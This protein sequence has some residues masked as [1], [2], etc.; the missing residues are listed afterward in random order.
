MKE[1][2]INECE[3][4]IQYCGGEPV[5]ILIQKICHN[6]SWRLS[7]SFY[8]CKKPSA[9]SACWL[10]IFTDYMY[11]IYQDL[12]NSYICRY[13]IM[14]RDFQEKYLL[15]E[16]KDKS[17]KCN[18]KTLSRLNCRTC[19]HTADT[20]RYDQNF[21]IRTR[22]RKTGLWTPS[23]SI[24]NKTKNLKKFQVKFRSII[25]L[26]FHLKIIILNS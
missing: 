7:N 21:D 26:I 6:G 16:G 22:T 25:C 3:R 13:I 12:L 15:L 4:T 11:F 2:N 1:R 14:Y 20:L 5:L 23:H 10:D 17:M 18:L 8:D 24:L 9:W 19:L